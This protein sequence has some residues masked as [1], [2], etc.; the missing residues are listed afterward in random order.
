MDLTLTNFF[1]LTIFFTSWEERQKVVQV[2]KKLVS[3][4]KCEEE[5]KGKEYAF[6]N[7]NAHVQW[8][9]GLTSVVG[10]GGG[11]G[12]GGGAPVCGIPHS[13]TSGSCSC[14]GSCLLWMT[15]SS[16]A[17]DDIVAVKVSTKTR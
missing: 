4:T 5:V 17:V 8:L 10:G 12:G 14:A 3:Y 15:I 16:L 11:D 6:E 13:V 1:T 7:V 2:V 9:E